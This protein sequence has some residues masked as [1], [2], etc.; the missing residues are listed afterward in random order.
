MTAAILTDAHAA[1]PQ[2]AAT[3]QRFEQICNRGQLTDEDRA[4]PFVRPMRQ[5]MVA[6]SDAYAACEGA[7]ASISRPQCL[8]SCGDRAGT[9]APTPPRQSGR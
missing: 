1:A 5:D 8:T 6:T 4:A 2:T 7:R 3:A 9:A